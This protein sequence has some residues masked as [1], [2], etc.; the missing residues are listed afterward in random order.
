[1]AEFA[2]L[3]IRHLEG[4][5]DSASAEDPAAAGRAANG[6]TANGEPPAAWHSPRR[7]ARAPAGRSPRQRLRHAGAV[8]DVAC[9][10]PSPDLLSPGRAD[11]GPRPSSER[12]R[13]RGASAAAPSA[14]R[15]CPAVEEPQG[16]SP[17]AGGEGSGED[18]EL[19][20]RAVSFLE[21]AFF[22]FCGCV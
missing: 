6:G 1:M 8:P 17:A 20:M 11:A 13:S 18:N 9:E 19:T 16:D 15:G 5:F 12:K 3:G 7:A 21:G 14:K 10:P 2:A 4:E 22:M